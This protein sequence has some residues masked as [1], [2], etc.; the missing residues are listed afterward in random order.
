[1]AALVAD[2]GGRAVAEKL[3]RGE[4]SL[5]MPCDGRYRRRRRRDDAPDQRIL[6]SKLARDD[7]PECVGDRE[8]V[9]ASNLDLIVCNTAQTMESDRI[10]TVLLGEGKSERAGIKGKADFAVTLIETRPIA[11]RPIMLTFGSAAR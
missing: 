3:V 8:T 5:L 11:I 2:F 6:D 1:M 7:G 10:R 9:V 4:R